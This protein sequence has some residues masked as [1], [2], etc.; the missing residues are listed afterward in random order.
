MESLL[1]A[2]KGGADAVYLGV[3]EFNARQGAAN[4]SVE[5]LA[6]AIDTAHAYGVSVYLALN[7]PVKQAELPQVAELVDSAYSLG[8]D[9]VI[10]RDIG[11]ISLVHS[12]YPDLEIHAST[13][14]TVHNTAGVRFLESLGVNRAIVARE[15]TTAELQAIAGSSG[16]GIEVF[17]HGAL[18]YS[19][20]GQCLFS[21]FTTG[22]S[23]NRGACAQPCRWKFD[24][25]AGGKKRNK[26]IGG[27]FPVSCAELCTLSGIGEIVNSGVSSLKI[28]GRMKKP[29]YVAATARIYREAVEKGAIDEVWMSQKEAELAGLFYRGFTKGFVLGDREVTHPAYSSNHGILLGK[30]QTVAFTSSSA[31]LKLTLK[32]NIEAGDGISIFTRQRMLGSSVRTILKGGKAVSQAR[33]GD[34][35]S[36]LISPRTGKAVSRGDEICLTTDA[37]LLA[38]L[39]ELELP[40]RPVDITV[41]AAAGKP[42]EIRVSDGRSQV[43]HISDYIVQPSRKAPTGGE[44]IRAV[45]EKL[46]ETPYYLSGFTVNTDGDIFIPLGVLAGA[47]RDACDQLLEQKLSVFR[48]PAR[49]P[50][51]ESA[52]FPVDENRPL[53]ISVEVGDI[54]CLEAAFENGADIV[55]L[56]VSML[57]EFRKDL[58]GDKEVVFVLPQIVHDREM[59]S[60]L[61]LLDGVKKHGYPVE[62]REPGSVMLAAEKGLPF[63]AGRALNTFNS[64]SAAALGKAGAFR[65]FLSP[66][67][68]LEE[69]RELSAHIDR[70]QIRLEVVAYGRQLLFVTGHD[71]LQPLAAKGILRQDSAAYLADKKGDRYPVK[72]EG[73]R[74]LLYDS[75]VINMSGNLNDLHEAGV[76]AIRLEMPYD[77]RKKVGSIVKTWREEVERKR[78]MTSSRSPGHYTGHYYKGV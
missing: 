61:P 63:V 41:D 5:G 66:E 29:E 52:A 13:Q 4:F 18:C 31:S 59:A 70:T 49:H 40:R 37:S 25:L 34:T 47:R 62:C 65:V 1:A 58:P 6:G 53:L 42:L 55:Y 72:K 39:R 75:R 57:P 76:S 69:I 16:T 44:Q 43:T 12:L 51:M 50:V 74:T 19:Y 9:A 78:G 10:L 23:A 3:G 26:E 8:I 46:G 71:L 30:V 32:Q 14:M 56:P 17:V 45:M 2:I 11:L 73:T 68:S 36:L 33:A 27:M 20:S 15:L 77:S 28:E 7:I 21:S 24:L 60:L 48:R 67:L 54:A 38:G 64:L 35:V 22:R